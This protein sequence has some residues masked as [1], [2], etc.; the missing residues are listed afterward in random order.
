LFDKRTDRFDRGRTKS[1]NL[2]QDTDSERKRIAVRASVR[3]RM[4]NTPTA[5]TPKPLLVLPQA[6]PG[7]YPRESRIESIATL[8]PEQREAY[9]AIRAGVIAAAAAAECNES[10]FGNLGQN[11]LL[12]TGTPIQKIDA[13]SVELKQDS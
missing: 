3:T 9:R 10:S 12:A 13:A 7:Q 2:G 8:L 1:G 4:A 5:R 11:G 6:L